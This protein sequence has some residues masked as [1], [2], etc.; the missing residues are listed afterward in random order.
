MQVRANGARQLQRRPP[1]PEF[2][3]HVLRDFLRVGPLAEDTRRTDD[4]C[5]VVLPEDRRVGVVVAFAKS[6]EEFRFVHVIRV[7][8]QS[9]PA[10]A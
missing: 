8:G 6:C 4:E 2:Q 5:R 7:A 9:S 1:P 10:D 3:Q